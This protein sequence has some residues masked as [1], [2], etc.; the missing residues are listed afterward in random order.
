MGPLP[1]WCIGCVKGMC[2]PQINPNLKKATK[3]LFENTKNLPFSSLQMI[4]LVLKYG[5]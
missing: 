4:E 1:H 2:I 3:I 5:A